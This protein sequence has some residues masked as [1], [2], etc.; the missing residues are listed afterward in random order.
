[1][2]IPSSLLILTPHSTAVCAGLYYLRAATEERH[3]RAVSPEY[4]TYAADVD[5]RWADSLT[6]LTGVRWG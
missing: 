6:W 4:R 3:L 1:M 2:L 5:R